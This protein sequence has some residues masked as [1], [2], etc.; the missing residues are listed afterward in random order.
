ML[1]PRIS[2]LGIIQGSIA[3]FAVALIGKAAYV[4]LWQGEQW[5]AR[6]ASQHFAASSLPAP[7]G[8]IL[9]GTGTAIVQSRDLVRLNVA[10]R[11]LRDPKAL[12]KAL[13]RAGVPAAWV[14]RAT[15][16]RKG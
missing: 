4:Q 11:E 5:A 9:D 14:A 16:R 15:D 7:R 1:R 13:L 6:A 3:L 8:D 2:R 12:R 10:P